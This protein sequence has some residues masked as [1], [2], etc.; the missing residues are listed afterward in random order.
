MKQ[1]HYSIGHAGIRLG[2]ARSCAV[3][4]KTVASRLGLALGDSVL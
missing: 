4:Y 3:L 2:L 1:V